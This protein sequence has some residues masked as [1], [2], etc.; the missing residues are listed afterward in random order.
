MNMA[1]CTVPVHILYLQATVPVQRDLS[2]QKLLLTVVLGVENKIFSARWRARDDI[3]DASDND[4]LPFHLA[5]TSNQA[6]QP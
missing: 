6:D 3:A 2:Q 5:T 4:V 1:I